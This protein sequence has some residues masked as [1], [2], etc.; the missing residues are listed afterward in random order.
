MLNYFLKFVDDNTVFFLSQT[1]IGSRGYQSKPQNVY[2][3]LKSAGQRI[4]SD[5]LL[6]LSETELFVDG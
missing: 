2:R 5:V 4:L 1:K 6:N 3:W